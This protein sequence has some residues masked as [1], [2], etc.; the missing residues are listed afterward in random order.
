MKNKQKRSQVGEGVTNKFAVKYSKMFGISFFSSGTNELL[1]MLLSKI[2]DGKSKTWLTTVNPEFIMGARHDNDFMDIINKS[3]IKVI[4]GIGLLWA[5][6]TLKTPKGVKRYWKALVAGVNILRGK[7]REGLICGS[8]LVMDFCKMAAENNQKVFLL[9][10]W[11][12]RAEESGKFLK[13][14]FPGL[15]YDFCQGEPGVENSEVVKKI[16]KFQPDFLLVAYGMKRQE[17]WIVKNID[18]LKVKVVV[19]VGRSFDYY[20][21]AL[22]RAPIWL[23]KM[24]LEWLY[25]LIKEPKRGKRQLVLPKFIWM[26]LTEIA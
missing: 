10:G 20:S 13:K 8:D 1:N 15:K 7:G 9:G 25:S 12:N 21:G 22:K 26:V 3:D 14:K 6:E 11:Q 17:E 23:R 4:D 2:K 16:N 24:G 18:Q 5:K 19:G